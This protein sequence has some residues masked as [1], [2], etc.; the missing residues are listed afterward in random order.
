MYKS[1]QYN[2]RIPLKAHQQT[3]HLRRPAETELSLRI[4][5]L[6][7]FLSMFRLYVSLYIWR[8]ICPWVHTCWQEVE[9]SSICLYQTPVSWD[10]FSPWAWGSLRTPRI[11]CLLKARRMPS[12]W[13]PRGPSSGPQASHSRHCAT[14]L[15]PVPLPESLTYTSRFSN[16]TGGSMM[17][18]F[19]FTFSILKNYCTHIRHLSL[20]HTYIFT[21]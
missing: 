10:R 6:V 12:W 8:Y 9:V 14:E 20:K 5:C 16:V 7:G 18:D 3:S 11:C 19:P 15:L 21:D 4:L 13:E 2:L 1:K 17:V